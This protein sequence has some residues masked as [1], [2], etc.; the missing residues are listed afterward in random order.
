M[1]ETECLST[2]E[3]LS[4]PENALLLPPSVGDDGNALPDFYASL[5]YKFFE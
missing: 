1:V 3:W 5:T 4:F 2:G